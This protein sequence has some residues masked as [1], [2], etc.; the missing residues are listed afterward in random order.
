M[1][2][3]NCIQH[4]LTV[5]M[6]IMRRRYTQSKPHNDYPIEFTFSATDGGR[7]SVSLFVRGSRHTANPLN[8]GRTIKFAPGKSLRF[9][10]L[11]LGILLSK[12]R[13]TVFLPLDCGVDSWRVS[14]RATRDS[15]LSWRAARD[16]LKCWE[17][18]GKILWK[19]FCPFHENTGVT[20]TL[21]AKDPQNSNSEESSEN[22]ETF[23]SSKFDPATGVRIQERIGVVCNN[24]V[25]EAPGTTALRPEGTPAIDI[26]NRSHKLGE[27]KDTRM[28]FNILC[29][30][31]P[32]SVLLFRIH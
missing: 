10:E 14:W 3:R 30:T 28:L 16:V 24:K 25:S 5:I 23:S 19:Q 18:G 4:T 29:Y 11:F 2:Y 13:F 12:F 32:G 26:R 20:L 7:E 22:R 6:S 17:Y 9:S 21:L 31:L 27:D 8:T 15:L 1:A